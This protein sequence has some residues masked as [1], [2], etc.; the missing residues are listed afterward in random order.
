VVGGRLYVGAVNGEVYCLSTSDG[1]VLWHYQTGSAIGGSPAYDNGVVFICSTNHYLYAFNTDGTLKWQTRSNATIARAYTDYFPMSTP[2]IGDGK[3]FWGAGPV[4]GQLNVYCLNETDGSQIWMTRLSGNTPLHATPVYVP[5]FSYTY[6]FP[7]RTQIRWK[8]D[9][10]ILPEFMGI[11][12]WN[13]TNGQKIWNQWLGHEV[14][15][16]PA[17][18]NDIRCPRFY[19]GSNTYSI[20]CFNA[21]A[22]FLDVDGG[23]MMGGLL[24]ATGSA[25]LGVYTT[26]SHIQASPAIWDGKVY[27][28]SADGKM[29]MFDQLASC[30]FSISAAANKAGAMWNNETLMIQG[31]LTP[32]NTYMD[33]GVT[34]GSYD[35][36]GLPNATVKL[37]LT[38]PDQTDVSMETTTDANGYFSFSYNPTDVGDWGWV[39]YFEG[40]EHPYTIYNQ[41]YGEWQTVSVTSPTAGGETQP[42]PSGGGI[43]MEYVYVA[44]A[45]IVIVLVAIGAYILLRRGK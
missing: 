12:V 39:V 13:A 28:G 25:V 22:A 30:D 41:A 34:Y 10:L 9:A 37:S 44:V 24:P 16:S 42:P 43:P 40:G 27:I 31:R 15:S 19:V 21:T 36:N 20:T 35:A 11:S 8:L 3:V 1:N 26:E 14:Y 2:T 5:G 38:K 18:V 23:T 17:Y 4:Y 33:L 7:N 45:V 6:T 29:Y 32:A